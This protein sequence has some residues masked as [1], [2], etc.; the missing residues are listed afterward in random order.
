MM[1]ASLPALWQH[2]IRV[3]PPPGLHSLLRS[4]GTHRS[5]VPALTTPQHSPSAASSASPPGQSDPPPVLIGQEEK[6]EDNRE[7]C[8]AIVT[9]GWVGSECRALQPK[10]NPFQAN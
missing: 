5:T 3:A 10:P 2:M 9:S 6:P 4:P 8:F 1:E 7:Y